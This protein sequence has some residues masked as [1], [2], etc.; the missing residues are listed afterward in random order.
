MRKQDLAR[1]VAARTR[2]S[3][4]QATAAVTA[5]FA[6]IQEAM[7][8]GDEVTISGFGSFRAVE[9]AAREARNPRTR[10]PIQIGPRRSPAFRPGSALKRAVALPDE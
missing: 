5:V 4:A 3:E 9:R 10:D 7:A 1:A 8:D 6:V 2:T